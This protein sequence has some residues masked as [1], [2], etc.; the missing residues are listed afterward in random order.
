M[1]RHL[2]AGLYQSETERFVFGVVGDIDAEREC[3]IQ[4]GFLLICRAAAYHDPFAWFLNDLGLA[5]GIRR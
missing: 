4:F 1:R 3:D 2:L 5:F